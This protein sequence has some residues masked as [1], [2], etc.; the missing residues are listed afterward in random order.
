[1]GFFD[2]FRKPGPPPAPPPPPPP[3]APSVP[4]RA[5]IQS[6][7]LADGVG[8]LELAGGGTLRF[9]RS[10]CAGFEPVV[11]AAVVVTQVVSDPRGWKA[12]AVSLDPAEEGYDA[13]LAAR[14]AEMGL[15]PRTTDLAN[16]A[17]T[18]RRLGVL[19]ILL[20]D[21]LPTGA[22]ALGRW[23]SLGGLPRDGIT[24]KTERDLEFSVDLSTVLT[25]P[26][27]GRMPREGL[28]LTQVPEG[29]DLGASFLGF[30]TGIPGADRQARIALGMGP[31]P[32]APRG[33][34]RNISRLVRLLAD[35]ATGV[36]IHRAV[37]MVLPIER[38]LQLSG[39]IDDPDCRP[40]GAWL[41]L[42]IITHDDE[43]VYATFGM[44]AFGLPDV[45]T[46]V[47]EEDPE[48]H[49]RAHEAVMLACHTMVRQDRELAPGEIL[50]V[51]EG[52]RVGAWPVQPTD[53]DV[54]SYVVEENGE[55]LE[56]VLH[57]EEDG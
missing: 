7:M 27:R 37:D 52:V 54:L 15:L 44:D 4:A 36:V 42:G 45:I 57:E 56:L 28:D 10:A 8:V 18:A 16:A 38:F 34:L 12:R 33:G 22:L 20:R 14:D 3:T 53:T 17:E 29:F 41:D 11:G 9:G 2:R 19:T 46:E 43:R 39:D 55:L 5:R 23:A 21:P 35:Q 48:D 49:R 6:Y 30:G 40:F 51:P 13:L 50:E 31:D 32:W 24:V 25:Y 1:M 26:G 47:D